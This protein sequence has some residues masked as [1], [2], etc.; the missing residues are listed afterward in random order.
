M[1]QA[2]TKESEKFERNEM[3]VDSRIKNDLTETRKWTMFFAILG[4]IGIGFL[5][6]AV[7]VML[8]AATVGSGFMSN[9]NAMLFGVLTVVYLIMGLLYFFPVY[10]LLKFSTHMKSAIE[11]SEQNKLVMAFEYLK[12]HYKFI[13]ILT[14]VIIGMYI[15]IGIVAAVVGF[16]SLF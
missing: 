7:V 4:F 3:V 11:K 6:I 2:E 8:I 14:I 16:S 10:Y 1:E 12:S 9:Q 5:A 15:L 13:G